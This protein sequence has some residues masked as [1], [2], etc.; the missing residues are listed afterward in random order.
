MR[1]DFCFAFEQ[2][3]ERITES[4]EME[5]KISGGF[6]FHANFEIL[7]SYKDQSE[8]DQMQMF[9]DLVTIYF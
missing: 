2:T 4:F 6:I 9:I 3:Q 7:I 8:L 5:R 1:A